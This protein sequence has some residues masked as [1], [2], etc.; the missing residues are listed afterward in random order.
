MIAVH[1]EHTLSRDARRQRRNGGEDSGLRHDCFLSRYESIFSGLMFQGISCGCEQ[2]LSAREAGEVEEECL[3]R[4]QREQMYLFR[5]PSEI[6]PAMSADT[7]RTRIRRALERSLK[8]APASRFAEGLGT[9][10]P[11]QAPRPQVEN[12]IIAVWVMP[13]ELYSLP[14]LLY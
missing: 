4:K 14:W 13:L 5:R 7:L 1:I 9:T 3:D 8:K 11:R 6:H 2:C 12:G 10:A